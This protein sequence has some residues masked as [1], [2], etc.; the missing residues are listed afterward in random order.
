MDQWQR[1]RREW[2]ETQIQQFCSSHPWE[3]GRIRFSHPVY[4][5]RKEQRVWMAVPKGSGLAMNEQS[6]IS[7]GANDHFTVTNVTRRG[8]KMTRILNV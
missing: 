4:E 2:I 7:R 8:K 6:D 1:W 5:I 3:K